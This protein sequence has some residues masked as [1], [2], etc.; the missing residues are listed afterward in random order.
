[1]SNTGTKDFNLG[2]PIH[3]FS[4]LLPKNL[5]SFVPVLNMLQTNKG[6]CPR[7]G[8]V[9]EVSQYWLSYPI[10]DSATK[11]EYTE[12]TEDNVKV[13]QQLNYN[14]ILKDV[15]SWIFPSYSYPLHKSENNMI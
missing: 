3:N 14:F 10:D 5:L 4:V 1:M 8:R 9:I 12:I 11:Y 2:H 7:I 15:V 13:S 6:F